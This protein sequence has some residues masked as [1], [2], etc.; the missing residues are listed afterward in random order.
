MICPVSNNEQIINLVI[1]KQLHSFCHRGHDTIQVQPW[2]PCSKHSV[3]YLR[4]VVDIVQYM[5]PPWV[6]HDGSLPRDAF[7]QIEVLID[8]GFSLILLVGNSTRSRQAMH[9][10]F[11]AAK[12]V[13]LECILG[14]IWSL[15][16]KMGLGH[17]G[18]KVGLG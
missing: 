9:G 10:M 3:M 14:L 8:D 18:S 13:Y 15:L 16:M 4:L 11:W 12:E 7:G 6:F 17:M 5:V 1:R 2:I